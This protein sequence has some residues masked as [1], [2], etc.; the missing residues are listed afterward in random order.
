[1]S[2]VIAN[3]ASQRRFSCSQT[4]LNISGWSLDCDAPTLPIWYRYSH[5]ISSARLRNYALHNKSS[6]LPKYSICGLIGAI[7][8][9]LDG[10]LYAPDS[11]SAS[12]SYACANQVSETDSPTVR[13]LRH[14]GLQS[15]SPFP[16]AEHG[17][18]RAFSDDS[19]TIAR[20]RYYRMSDSPHRRTKF[21]RTN[22]RM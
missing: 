19:T 5:P 9:W 2:L 12:A 13:R 6:P 18:P 1:M 22:K 11:V 16:T 7:R 20:P 14:S 4:H 3:A 10:R 8:Y 17:L 15:A 21:P